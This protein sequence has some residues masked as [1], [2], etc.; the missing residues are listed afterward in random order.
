MLSYLIIKNITESNVAV[1]DTPKDLLM[2]VIKNFQNFQ[3][4]H[5]NN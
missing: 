4:S 3:K 1:S 2:P 5:K